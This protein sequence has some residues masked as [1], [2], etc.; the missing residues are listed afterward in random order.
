VNVRAE[1]GSLVTRYQPFCRCVGL[2]CLLCLCPA[3][4]RAQVASPGNAQS[5]GEATFR[6]DV[7]ERAY[8]IILARPTRDSVTLAILAYQHLEGYVA[9]GTQPGSDPTW[10][11]VRTFP[12]GQPVEVV[13]TGLQSDTG[14][15]YQFCFRVPTAAEFDMSP[16]YRFHTQRPPGSA[17]TFTI[18][19]DPHLDE[20]TTPELYRQTMLNALAD[21]PD[22]HIDL[23]DT[24]MTGKHPDTESAGK[25]YL[26]QRYYFG[27]LCH[28]A[29]L[30]LV[31]GNHDGET[32][33][34]QDGTAGSTAVWANSIRKQY[35]PNPV[36]EGFYTGN[37]TPH[38]FAGRLQD[39]Y[40]W[41]WGDALFVVLD[42]YWH[43]PRRRGRDDNWTP[44][45]GSEQ[46][47]WL[48]RTLEGSDAKYRFVFIHQLVGGA[49]R[50]GRGGVEVAPLYE[51]G[52]GN[53][54]GSD[55]LAAHRPGWPMS[56]HQLLVAHHVSAV[57]HGHDHLFA[58]QHLDGILYQAVPQ[59]GWGG[60]FD[61]R[62]AIEYGYTQGTILGSSGHL[63]VTVSDT[64][65]AVE[66]IRSSLP[67]G[68]DQAASVAHRCSLVP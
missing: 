39:Y 38:P 57:F 13:L 35:F 7:P 30:F 55:G 33:R 65:A 53:A 14:Y 52:G 23:G 42:P 15:S 68:Q 54:D 16:E 21:R 3:L 48:Q 25:Q 36:P 6:T 34:E 64:Q 17:Y 49:D 27:L 26:A 63:R 31:L 22:F 40:A 18:T 20:Q 56:I 43:S 45:L 32:A 47:R 44:T 59:P 19:A 58:E 61:P 60:R 2:L 50:D 5:A 12:E 24:F 37:D 62:R 67:S 41:E 28:S 8:D 66:Y 4:G 10:T 51:W 1:P 9:Y 46:Y 11:P 29:P